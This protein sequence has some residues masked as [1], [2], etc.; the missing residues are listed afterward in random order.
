MKKK[1]FPWPVADVLWQSVIASFS[2]DQIYVCSVIKNLRFWCDKH[3]NNNTNKL[4]IALFTLRPDCW[5]LF[6]LFSKSFA[7][8]NLFVRLI[9][10]CMCMFFVRYRTADLVTFFTTIPLVVVSRIFVALS[11]FISVKWTIFDLL[12]NLSPLL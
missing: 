6:D 10:S 2:K 4:I 8:C 1:C 3:L 12:L 11:R 9:A 7:A 5:C